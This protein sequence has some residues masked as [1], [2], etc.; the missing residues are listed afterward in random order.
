MTSLDDVVRSTERRLLRLGLMLSGSVHNAE[1]LVQSVLA[2]AHRQWDR[3]GGLDHPEAYLRTM[4]VNEYLGW[5]RL[6]KNREVP[7]AEPLE[8]ATYDDHGIRQAQR[9]ATWRLLA[10]LPRKQRAV[11]VLRYYEDLTDPDIA[12]ILGVS[13]A[14]VRSNAAR[15]LATLRDNLSAEEAH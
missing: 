15:A 3:I 1:D 7:L 14:T 11:L 12:E 9:D 2:R 13:P 4:V 8:P 10:R 6:L 5:R